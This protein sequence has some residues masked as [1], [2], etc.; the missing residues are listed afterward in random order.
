MIF[1]EIGKTGKKA[2]IIGHGC[3]H[4]DR[5]PYEQVKSTID[6]ALDHGIN[7]FDMF[8]PGQEIREFLAKALGARRK[9][10][11]IQG[12]ICSTDIKQQYDISRDMPTV[13]RYFEEHLRLCGGHIDFGMLFFIDSDDDYKNVFETGIADYA[14]KLK[15]KGDISHIGFSSHNPVNAIKAI[16]TGLPE[17][18]MFSLNPA[19]DIIPAGD[20]IFTHLDNGFN[21]DNFAGIEPKRAELYRLCEQKNV[22]ITV[23]KALG[24]GKLISP[25]HSPFKKPL[26]TAQCIHY[27]LSKPA[28][29][30]VLP[31]CKTPEEIHDVVKYLEL[32]D[33]ERD[34]TE[35]LSSIKGGFH[36]SCV[37]C[38]HCQPCP[39]EI[40]IATVNKYLDIALLDSAN[41]PPSIRSHYKAL[42][43]SGA[44]CTKCGN[45]EKRCPFGVQ[46][47]ENMEKAEKLLGK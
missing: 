16:N 38:S 15:E 1:R 44:E 19:F 39:A 13:Q 20:S 37:Y 40:D 45:C 7:I 28:V 17:I 32:S 2:S 18:M 25:E 27:A 6:A 33:A 11:L 43:H 29:V 23:M 8:M 3:E 47:I 46:I 9:D 41:V 31:G 12:H 10:V 30:S 22:G 24:A 35:V 26:T 5:K 36:G 14:L 42:K 21:A 34:Y 4:L